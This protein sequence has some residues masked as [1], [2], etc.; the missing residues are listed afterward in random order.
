MYHNDE[1]VSD[2]V[3]DSCAFEIVCSNFDLSKTRSSSLV[4]INQNNIHTI[5]ATSSCIGSRCFY[6]FDISVPILTMDESQFISNFLKECMYHNMLIRII[7]LI[8][9]IYYISTYRYLHI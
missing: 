1:N 9:Y 8:L 4:V 3:H 2:M 5:L 7:L 6:S